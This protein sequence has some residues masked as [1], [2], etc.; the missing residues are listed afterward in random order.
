MP[1]QPEEMSVGKVDF[2]RRH[3]LR[4]PEQE[5]AVEET[6]DQV[7][8]HELTTVRISFPD[9][10]GI[11]RGKTLTPRDFAV[12]LRNGMDFPSDIV[13]FDTA[14]EPAFPAFEAGGGF[15]MPEMTGIPNVLLV[16]DPTTFRVLPWAEKTGWVLSDMYFDNGKPVPFA[17]RHVLRELLRDLADR[18]LEYVSG[19]EVEW[20]I[21][22]LEDPSLRPE[23]AGHP[24]DPPRVSVIAHGFQ[25]MSETRNDEID[26][27][28]QILRE[29]ITALGLPLRSMED[30]W[31]PGQCEFTFDPQRGLDAA[32]AMILFRT[33]AKQI[34]RR[35]GYLASFMCRPGIPNLYSSGWHLHQSLLRRDTGENVFQA[36]DESEP[37]SELGRHF[38]GGLLAHAAAAAVFTTPTINGYKR[39][40]PYSLAPTRATWGRDNRAAMIRV[41]DGN[42][43]N[44]HL[45]N[46]I[47]EPAA[48]PYLY[49]ASQLISGL[50]GVDQKLDPGPA[51]DEPYE[52]TERPLLPRSLMGAVE[53]L[54]E[55]SVFR[56]RLGDRFVDYLVQIKEH[57][58]ERFLS[59]VTDW[60]QREY[61]EMY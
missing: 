45:E 40:K 54:K 21:T 31:G 30:E 35:H 17:T 6:L 50:A 49:M 47:G 44:A 19:L 60:E 58:I 22:K 55:S 48:N 25:Y 12:A 16:P 37:L 11:A 41:I 53:A 52:A 15:D 32:D 43:P 39:F 20:Y 29:N 13:V 24:P 42:G 51:S 26:G 56:E 34:C 14:N 8:A 61:F 10:H 28:L 33:A 1:I 57:E 36:R 23:Q 38:V 59:Y 46:R 2:V 27:I 7:E 9:Q 4:T 5:R 3:G 18:G